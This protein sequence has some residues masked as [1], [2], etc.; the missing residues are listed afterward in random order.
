MGE[1]EGVDPSLFGRDNMP[2]RMDEEIER[3]P[4][5]V[6]IDESLWIAD[7]GEVWK[8]NTDLCYD[9]ILNRGCRTTNA[10]FQQ[11]KGDHVQVV[12]LN[13]E[14]RSCIGISREEWGDL[15]T[16]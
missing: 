9:T 2:L 13:G 1:P 4:V 10:I 6:R 7:N 16:E 15:K 12:D 14:S 11:R 5:E 8:K 3:P